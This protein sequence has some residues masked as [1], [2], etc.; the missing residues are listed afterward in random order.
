MTNPTQQPL[1]RHTHTV[2]GTQATS[3]SM[4]PVLPLDLLPGGFSTCHH[5]AEEIYKRGRK[6]SPQVPGGWKIR[7]LT[8]VTVRLT[9]AR[10]ASPARAPRPAGRA[11]GP[12][13]KQRHHLLSRPGKLRLTGYGN[14]RDF[15]ELSWGLQS[16]LSASL[17]PSF[18][19]P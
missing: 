6:K 13:V 11:S 2:Q 18:L 7:A 14:L 17:S 16:S 8:R 9:E 4:T 12:S 10:A 19:M 1:D 3:K 5:N 15:T